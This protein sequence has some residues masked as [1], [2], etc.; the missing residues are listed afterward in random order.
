[1]RAPSPFRLMKAIV[2]ASLTFLAM[3]LI[4]PDSAR[5]ASC[6]HPIDRPGI[7]LDAFRLDGSKAT[8]QLPPPKPCT[9]PSCSNKS[10]PPTTSTPPAPPRGEL[11][12][13]A[14][15]PLPVD[16]PD[17]TAQAPEGNLERPIRSAT[18]VFH[19]PRMTR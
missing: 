13:L 9:G 16:G 2:G 15:E 7:G 1:M 8:D 14:V 6:D 12:G 19:P 18:L 5:A 3:A 11:W 4:A 10:A 17:S